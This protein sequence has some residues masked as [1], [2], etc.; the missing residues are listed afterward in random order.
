MSI[1]N[2]QAS[3]DSSEGLWRYPSEH[4]IVIL[5]HLVFRTRF[6]SRRLPRRFLTQLSGGAKGT[7]A[8]TVVGKPGSNENAGVLEKLARFC[9]YFK[10]YFKLAQAQSD[11]PLSQK[12]RAYRKTAWRAHGEFPLCGMS[13]TRSINFLS[14][15]NENLKKKNKQRRQWFPR[16][17]VSPEISSPARASL[18]ATAPKRPLRLLGI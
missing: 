12:L 4:S 2:V 15:V 7:G 11:T 9:Q 8:H 10:F 6:H 1:R 18:R 3:N 13:T 14:C 16:S 17:V 5:L